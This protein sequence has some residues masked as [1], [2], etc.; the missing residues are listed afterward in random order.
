MTAE[1]RELLIKEMRLFA[2]HDVRAALAMLINGEQD[3]NTRAVADRIF[4]HLGDRFLEVYGDAADG[5]DL[6]QPS[7]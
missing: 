7:Q 1:E 6:T 4:H 5:P 3:D 2:L